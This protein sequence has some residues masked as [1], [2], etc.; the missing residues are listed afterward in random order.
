MRRDEPAVG[1]VPGPPASEGSRVGG[2]TTA[3]STR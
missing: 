2:R 1:R 3:S